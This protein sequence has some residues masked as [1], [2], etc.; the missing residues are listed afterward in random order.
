[1]TDAI[2][3]VQQIQ[4]TLTQLSAPA[5]TTP[6]VKT[7]S[8]SASATAFADALAATASGGTINN[9]GVTGA[10]VTAAAQKYLGVPYVFGGEDSTGMDCSG[11]VQRVFADLG[12]DVP[13]VV[14]DQMKI[15][16]EVPSLA[17]A[18]PG[19]LLVSRGGDHIAIYL[20]DNK[21]LHAPRPGKDVQIV[22]VYMS[23][24]EIDTIR[25][26][27]PADVAPQSTAL[28]GVSGLSGV[29]GLTGLAGGLSGLTGMTDP[30]SASLS[31]L[32]AAAQS[33]LVK[34]R[35]A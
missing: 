23:E 9:P 35:N 17:E 14:Q 11:L 15:G 32:I 31:D 1:M 13:R 7:A 21:L 29:S 25:R 33:A 12:I 22:D 8:T 3:R 10:D 28:A 6:A 27:V 30:S 34:G 16:T 5:T 20:G 4:Q 18:K 2:G 26:I 19:D 24:A